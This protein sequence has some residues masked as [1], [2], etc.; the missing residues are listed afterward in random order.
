MNIPAVTVDLGLGHLKTANLADS[1][2]VHMHL[3]DVLVQVSQTQ[4]LLAHGAVPSLAM[5]N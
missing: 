1:L 4:R 5:V 2:D 3:L